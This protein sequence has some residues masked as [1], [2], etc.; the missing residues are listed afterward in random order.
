VIAVATIFAVALI[1]LLL[2]R[3]AT[4]AFVLTG[5]SKEGARFQA[6]SALTGTGFTTSESEAVVNHPVRRRIV[7]TLMLCGGAGIVTT[8]A[9]LVIGFANAS[10]GQAFSRLGVLVAA[11][12]ALV[13]V[14]RTRW[15]DRAVSPL[16]T[17][18]VNR[19]TDLEAR[20]YA[21]LLHL[22]GDWS[23]GEVA[24]C[25]GDWLAWARL[26]DLDLR[27]EGVAVLG[28][29]RA[30]G[31]YLGAPRF[32]T[33]VAPGDVLLLYG[34]R[35]RL[36]ELDDRPAGPDGDRAHAQ[37]AADEDREAKRPERRELASRDRSGGGSRG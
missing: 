34:R 33:R 37:A 13:V 21:D 24:V 10:R 23:V 11:L 17:R 16:L 25:D 18:A 29:E 27:A 22:G 19:Y 3:V 8:I 5:M 26:A 14:S 9:T 12:G 20:D 7:M 6:R 31:E 30:G 36:R 15:F 2:T 32:D 28:I 1:S 4:I 35:H